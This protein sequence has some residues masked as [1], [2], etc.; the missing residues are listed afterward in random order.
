MNQKNMPAGNGAH[1]EEDVR[2]GWY[3]ILK[4][5]GKES[6]L[7]IMGHHSEDNRMA[8]VQKGTCGSAEKGSHYPGPAPTSL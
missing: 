5:K 3:N 1:V 7:R 2:T 8:A 4:S 6:G